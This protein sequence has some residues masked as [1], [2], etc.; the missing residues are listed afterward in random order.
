[1]S[2]RIEPLEQRVVP[3]V[4]YHGGPL[5]E[6]AYI[7]PV[8]YG[9]EWSLW[10]AAH[11]QT[12]QIDY[13][14]QDMTH[15]PWWDVLTSEYGISRPTVLP[16]QVINGPLNGV[17]WIDDTLIQKTLKQVAR[18]DVVFM[19]F[20][21]PGVAV[22]SEKYNINSQKNFT[23]YHYTDYNSLYYAVIPYPGP[24]ISVDN[25][26]LLP[27][28]QH[29]DAP[30]FDNLTCVASHELSEAVTDPVLLRGWYDQSYGMVGG[31]IADIVESFIYY[32]H[33]AY[34]VQA[35]SSRNGTPLYASDYLAY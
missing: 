12:A 28:K 13:V 3:T 27:N 32:Y 14:L 29:I 8:F 4:D 21:E 23:G 30:I 35:I 1:M 17:G 6:H 24:V 33:E 11:E 20:T 2:L 10:E 34:T 26:I 18:P 7:Q 25:E 16:G 9:S 15:S 22:S 5:L 31:E 19:V